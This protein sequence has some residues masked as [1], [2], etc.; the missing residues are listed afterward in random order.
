MAKPTNKEIVSK[1]E[2]LTRVNNTLVEMMDTFGSTLKEYIEFK[3]DSKDYQE[4]L[5]DKK[6]VREKIMRGANG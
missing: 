6:K 2:M 3:G 5:E 4:Y 1:V